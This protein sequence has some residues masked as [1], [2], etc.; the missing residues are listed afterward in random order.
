M[1]LSHT[2]FYQ[3]NMALGVL[4]DIINQ[5]TCMGNDLGPNALLLRRLLRRRLNKQLKPR[6]MS[7]L[8]LSTISLNSTSQWKKKDK[9]SANMELWS[10]ES[11]LAQIKGIYFLEHKKMNL[12][13]FFF[14]SLFFLSFFLSCF[15]VVVEL[16]DW[17]LY[18]HHK[19][20]FQS[21]LI[22][23]RFKTQHWS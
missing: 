10:S 19:H 21:S 16:I 1:V 13:W 20:K 3:S 23:F 22:S 11:A 15:L 6:L 9:E 14:F 2:T 18:T 7:R 12:W 4:K 8:L 5:I 17:I